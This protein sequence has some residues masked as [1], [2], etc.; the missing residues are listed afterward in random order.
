M[1]DVALA[2]IFIGGESSRLGGHPK[3]LLTSPSGP[4][5]VERWCELFREL[6]IPCVLVGSQHAYDRVPLESLPDEPHGTGPLGGLVA[7]LARAASGPVIA[8]ACDMPYVERR[9]LER[10][11][12][13]APSAN[14]VAPK[15]GPR[16]E[17]LFAR[18]DAAAV[19]PLARARV[20][21]ANRS[22]QGLLDQAG[23]V[24]LPL[25]AEEWQE[26]RDWDTWEAVTR[27]ARKR[28]S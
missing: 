25:E 5:I 18:Y 17:P 9:L 21:G 8:V 16:W 27:G 19:L 24:P 3:G 20:A 6:A 7:L 23:A 15:R 4:T 28:G 22:L 1:V 12:T 10:L 26:L 2:G 13:H 11:A 14:I